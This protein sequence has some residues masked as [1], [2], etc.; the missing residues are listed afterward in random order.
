MQ[1]TDPASPRTG[2]GK[3]AINIFLSD[4][5]SK[6]DLDDYKDSLKEINNLLKVV[7]GLVNDVIIETPKGTNEG[8]KI[9]I[10]H[11]KSTCFLPLLLSLLLML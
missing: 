5:L 7:E 11:T 1:L 10:I 8:E 6:E 2:P 9:I 4:N 3:N